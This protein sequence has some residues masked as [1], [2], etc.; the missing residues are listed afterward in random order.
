MLSRFGAIL[1]VPP[2]LWADPSL[3]DQ[4]EDDSMKPAPTVEDQLDDAIALKQPGA[5]SSKERQCLRCS[6]SFQSQWAGERICGRCKG[7]SAWRQGSP[8]SM[9]GH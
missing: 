5:D 4:L 1:Q 3:R 2:P 9:S 8:V 7:T 6:M